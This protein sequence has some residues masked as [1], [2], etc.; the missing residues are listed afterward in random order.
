MATSEVSKL[1]EEGRLPDV[2]PVG[3]APQPVRPPTPVV[4]GQHVLVTSSGALDF[5][6]KSLRFILQVAGQD[7]ITAA[8]L[9]ALLDTPVPATVTP[10]H[11]VTGL[12]LIVEFEEPGAFDEIAAV[13]EDARRARA[14]LPSV[15]AEE[16]AKAAA[17][18]F[19]KREA[20]AAAQAEADANAAHAKLVSDVADEVMKRQAAAQ[21]ASPAPPANPNA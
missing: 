8:L 12:T 5:A 14:G 1:Q 17:E 20:D 15:G 13:Q 4:E 7:A 2:V 18:A 21:P 19:D 10:K 9:Q 16:A 3:E 6:K 11:D